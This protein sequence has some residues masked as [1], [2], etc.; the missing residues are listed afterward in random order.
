MGSI[1][2]L[3][4][5]RA[6]IGLAEGSEG[7]EGTALGSQAVGAAA[8]GGGLGGEAEDGCGRRCG[9]AESGHFV[10][11]QVYCRGMVRGSCC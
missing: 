7:R 11:G 3:G 2:G 8:R 1:G 10:G 6:F 4:H 5:E 9:G